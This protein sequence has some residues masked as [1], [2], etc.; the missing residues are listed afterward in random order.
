MGD[1]FR[2]EESMRQVEL[3][4]WKDVLKRVDSIVRS[5]EIIYQVRLH[6]DLEEISLERL[7]PTEEFLENDKLALVFQKI[8]EE[9][10]DVPITAVS[11]GKDYFVLDGHHRAFI[12]KK[13]MFRSIGAYVLTFPE[14][15]GY[16]EVPMRPLEDLRIKDVGPI[17][18]PI[19]RTWQRIL[20]V[21]EHYEAIYSVPFYLRKERVDL[22]DLVPTQS[23]VGKA[24]ID[25]MEKLL[26]PIVCVQDGTKYYILDGHARSLRAKALGLSSIEAMILQSPVRMNF[27]IVKTAEAMELRQLG[28]VKIME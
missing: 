27:G 17:E 7:F 2:F 5:L 11:R 18:D 4:S 3:A 10:Y 6:V 22:R 1:Y 9:D 8:V 21:V 12:R 26:V 14:G 19:L 24:Q 28:D 20:F 23:H 25:A 15:A 13:L 16:R